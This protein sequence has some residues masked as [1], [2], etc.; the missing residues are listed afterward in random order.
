MPVL[1]NLPVMTF[2]QPGL[3]GRSDQC[4]LQESD[5]G[6]GLNSVDRAEVKRFCLRSRAQDHHIHSRIL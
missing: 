1:T 3:P 6:S 4:S 5:L 2:E